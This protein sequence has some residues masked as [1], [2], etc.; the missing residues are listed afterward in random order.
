MPH[1]FLSCFVIRRQRD[2]QHEEAALLRRPMDRQTADHLQP[3]AHQE[4][5]DSS[6]TIRTPAL[7]ALQRWGQPAWLDQLLDKL[8]SRIRSA[9]DEALNTWQAAATASS[10]VAPAT[11]DMEDVVQAPML[12]S[13]SESMTGIGPSRSFIPCILHTD[14]QPGSLQNQAE[15][16][17][18]EWVEFVDL[19][20]ML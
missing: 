15:N 20:A 14:S 10:P 2:T 1:S 11:L 6:A 9:V 18:W 16:Q 3:S 13:I 12:A 4:G 7:Q 17:V 19:R 8:D 5:P